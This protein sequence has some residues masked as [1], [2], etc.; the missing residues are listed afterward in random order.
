V[1]YLQHCVQ[2]KR[3]PL[4]SRTFSDYVNRLAQVGL[5]ISERARVKGKVRLFKIVS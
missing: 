1:E 5:I 3:K 4:A 2:A